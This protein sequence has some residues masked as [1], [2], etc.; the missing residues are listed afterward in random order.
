MNKLTAY[1]T[2][3]SRRRMMCECIRHYHLIGRSSVLFDYDHF[4]CML[5]VKIISESGYCMSRTFTDKS[6]IM[7]ANRDS[8]LIE[9]LTDCIEELNMIEDVLIGHWMVN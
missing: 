2:V 7:C 8:F 9:M 5:H 6:L 3:D 4:L 1:T